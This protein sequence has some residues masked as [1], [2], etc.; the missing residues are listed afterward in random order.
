MPQRALVAA[1]SLA[2]GWTAVAAPQASEL[3]PVVVTATATDRLASDAPASISVITR[4]QIQA[5]AVLDLS[6]ALRGTT[7]VT[8]AGVGFGR[9]GIRIRGMDPEYTLVLLDGQRVNAASDA[10][11][12]ADFDLG[13][14]PAAAIER[15]EVVRGPMSSL[16]GSEALGGVVNVISRRATDHWQGNLVYNGGVVDGNHGGNTLQAGLYAGGALVPGTLGLSVFAEHRHKD[17]TRDRTDPR[18]DEQEQRR[19]NTGR[20]VLTW[21]PDDQ[22]RID[23]SH[24]EGSE[25]RRRNALQ[26]G[27]APYVYA[28][29]DDIR[30]QQTTLSHQGDWSWGQTRF[31]AYQSRLERENRRDIGEATRPQDLRDDIVDGR[32]TLN[33]GASHRLSA[34]GEWRRE[35]LDDASAAASGKVEAIQTALFLQDEIQLT[36]GLSVVV[37][38]R[39]DHHAAFGWHHS[40]RAYAVW[41]LDDAF[42]LKGGVGTGFKAPSLKQ[43]SP[44]YSAVG[45]GGRF[46]IMGNPLL[47][48]EQTTSYELSGAWRHQG[49]SVQATV[50]QNEL[51]DLIQTVCV[52]ACGLRGR[53]LRNYTNVAQ[54]RIGGVELAAAVL[55]ADGLRLEANYSWLDTEDKETGQQL[56]ERP[57][58]SGAANLVWERGAVQATLRGEYVGP[59]KQASGTAQVTLPD[60]A[61]FSLDTRWSITPK[62]SLVAGIDNI[63]DKRLDE[64]GALYAYPETGRYVHA[65]FELAF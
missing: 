33:L 48:P 11:A 12:H 60:Y 7:G 16:Y 40:P 56:N 38:D 28:T 42:T 32:V 39:A 41:H 44:G 9:R 22:Q 29:S 52:R 58:R 61:L 49:W 65:G 43:L 21:T 23:L 54:A 8:L 55:L 36:D 30:R 18:L 26:A 19:V 6:D 27:T 4:E 64:T 51:K 34:G 24:L 63:A 37:G 14:M 46:T 2:C 35:R 59:Q 57:T 47:K 25:L 62:L 53:E 10:I 5:R 50:F 13:W 15:I 45:G 3:D 1:L 17:A 20:A 31:S